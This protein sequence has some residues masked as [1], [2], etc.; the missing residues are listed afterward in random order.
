MD[1]VEKAA[2]AVDK[3]KREKEKW[4]KILLEQRKKN[5]QKSLENAGNSLIFSGFG[6]DREELHIGCMLYA[7]EAMKEKPEL[8]SLFKEKG[9]AVLAENKKCGRR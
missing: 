8:E 2:K 1:L 3:A 4:S 5:H 9:A 6:L 7:M